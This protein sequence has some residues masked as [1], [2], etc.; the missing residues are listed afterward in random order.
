M[1]GKKIFDAMVEMR[2]AA[3]RN[4]RT[5]R[6]WE[7]NHAGLSSLAMDER[8]F[9]RDLAGAMLGTP[10]MAIPI[11]L[12]PC[13]EKLQSDDPKVDLIVDEKSPRG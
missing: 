6:R 13:G 9:C 3:L 10:F 1:T 2:S 11:T 8:I 12:M 7:I 4:G 5:P